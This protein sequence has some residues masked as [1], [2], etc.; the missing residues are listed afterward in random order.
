MNNGEEDS[1]SPGPPGTPNHPFVLAQLWSPSEAM[2]QITHIQLRGSKKT[3]LDY[4]CHIFP[5]N[6]NNEI[7]LDNLTGS[8]EG[9]G[10]PGCPFSPWE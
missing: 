8:P 9:P 1:T 5:D 7:A 10:F 4:N 3:H 2:R 6:M